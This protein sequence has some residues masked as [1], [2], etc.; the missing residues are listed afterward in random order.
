VIVGL[1]IDIKVAKRAREVYVWKLLR[2]YP[3]GLKV[4]V[5]SEE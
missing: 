1:N 4:G 3:L 5:E 2:H